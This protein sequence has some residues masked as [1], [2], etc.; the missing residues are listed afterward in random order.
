MGVGANHHDSGRAPSSRE[1]RL[2]QVG[3]Q[4][5]SEMIHP[6]GHLEAVTRHGTIFHRHP[7]VV[8]QQLDDRV[9][10]G[11]LGREGSHG[12][13]RSKIERHHVHIRARDFVANLL[14]GLLAFGLATNR[15]HDLEAGPS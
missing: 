7:G 13:Q 2:Q 6:E 1:L 10:R 11:D 4:E 5:V 15:D 8:H 12:G 9:F 14:G 3:E